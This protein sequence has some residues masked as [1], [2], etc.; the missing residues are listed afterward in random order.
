[1]KTLSGSYNSPFRSKEER[2]TSLLVSLGRGLFDIE[3]LKTTCASEEEINTLKVAWYGFL[4]EYRSLSYP[5]EESELRNG[6]Q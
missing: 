2:I 3:S 6:S 4:Q 5:V 1:M